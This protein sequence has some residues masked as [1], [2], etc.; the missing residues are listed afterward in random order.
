[1]CKVAIIQS[2]YI[3]WKGYFDII[4]MVDEFILYDDAQYTKRDWRNRNKIKTPDG[5]FWLTIPVKVK[6]RYL[7]KIKDTKVADKTWSKKHWQ[8]ISSYAYP[9]AEFF[10]KNKQFFEQLYLTS[11][12]EYLSDVNYKFIK[13]ICNLLN[14]KTKISWSMDYNICSESS[15]GKL[16]DLCKQVGAD[17]YLSGPSAK[18]YLEE[19]LFEEEDIK[20]NYIDYSSYPEYNQLSTPFEHHVSIIDLIFNV[21]PSVPKYMKS[22]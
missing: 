13:S 12:E 6:N 20:I 2:S 7:Q 4:N 17:E 16:I 19:K 8:T 10:D 18:D 11:D 9:G 1:M 3:P 15:T 21:G 5:L 14:I 22:F